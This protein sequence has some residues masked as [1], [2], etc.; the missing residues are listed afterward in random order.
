MLVIKKYKKAVWVGG[1]L[2]HDSSQLEFVPHSLA[3]NKFYKYFLIL[4]SVFLIFRDH[5]SHD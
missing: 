5:I 4:Q 1:R 2:G 3:Q